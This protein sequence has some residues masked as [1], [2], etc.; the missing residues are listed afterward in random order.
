MIRKLRRAGVVSSAWGGLLASVRYLP[1]R[2]EADILSGQIKND[3]DFRA[4]GRADNVLSQII[5]DNTGAAEQIPK[6]AR[7]RFIT[8]VGT[9]FRG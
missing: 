1:R 8:G 5:L 4:C 3:L 2:L 7:G 9:V 6:A